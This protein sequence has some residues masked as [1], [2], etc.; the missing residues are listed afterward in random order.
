MPSAAVAVKIARA[1]GVSVDYLVTGEEI[2]SA[3][4]SLGP[5]IWDLVQN[6][7]QL[8]EDD[9]NLVISIVQLLGNRGKRNTAP[10]SPH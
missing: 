10:R 9:R 3:K 2:S 1:L 6:F 5:E 4:S 8:S 7:K